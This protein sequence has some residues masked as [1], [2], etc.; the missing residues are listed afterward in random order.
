[1]HCLNC[2]SIQIEH[3]ISQSPSD[4]LDEWW[5]Y[6]CDLLVDVG[7]KDVEKIK[8]NYGK[9]MRCLEKF[10]KGCGYE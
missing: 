10:M 4:D 1:M 5:C 3:Q 9:R 2:G 6:G 7:L 8:R